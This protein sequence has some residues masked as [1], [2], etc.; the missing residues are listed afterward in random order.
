MK[1]Y[2]ISK[3]IR[4]TLPVL[5]TVILISCRHHAATVKDVI[6]S[7]ISYLYHNLD[8]AEMVSLD[9]EKAMSLFSDEEKEIL[10]TKYWIFDV[11]VPVV[12]SVMRSTV[13]KILPF[14][15]TEKGFQKTSLVMKNEQ[16]TYEVWQKLF[17]AGTV[18]LGINGFENYT[19]HYFISVAPQKAGDQL[20]LNNFFPAGQFVGTLD[21]G[22][23]LILIGMNWFCPMF[24]N[25]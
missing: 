13:Q 3:L 9:Y 15:L 19:L 6:D 21:D 23:I 16:V 25:L 22:L 17:N 2:L 18:G 10:A 11:N 4:L 1:Q 12:V 14:W 20:I 5:F 7:K 24:L 8:S